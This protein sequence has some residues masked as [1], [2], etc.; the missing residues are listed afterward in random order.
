MSVWTNTSRTRTDLVKIAL[1]ASL[2]LSICGG[3]GKNLCSRGCQ[4]RVVYLQCLWSGRQNEAEQF[5][6]CWHSQVWG[7]WNVAAGWRLPGRDA[8]GYQGRRG[9]Q[10]VEMQSLSFFPF[11]SETKYMKRLFQMQVLSTHH[12]SFTFLFLFVCRCFEDDQASLK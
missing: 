1:L 10:V 9:E 11:L 3:R 5:T 8:P 6:V 4:W 12:S 2:Y 7:L